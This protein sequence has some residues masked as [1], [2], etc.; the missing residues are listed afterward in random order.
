M[1]VLLGATWLS[2]CADAGQSYAEVPLLVSGS[3]LQQPVLAAGGVSLTVRRAELAFGPL[4]LCAGTQ[5]GDLCETARLEWLDSVRVD[6]MDP[7]PHRAGSLA[8][9]T[10]RVHSWMYDLGISSQLIRKDPFVLNAARELGGASL[11]VEGRANRGGGDV[12]FEVAVVIQQGSEAERG[13]P[14]VRKGTGEVF[15]H[16]VTGREQGLWVQFDAA[17]WL[18]NMDLSAEI[19]ASPCETAGNCSEPLRLEPDGQAYRALHNAAVSGRRPHFSFQP[20]LD[21]ENK[22]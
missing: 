12:P 10:G 20:Q 17:P 11:V 13:V 4:Y 2:A 19:A 21:F 15:N 1:L 16:D 22:R 5:A 7:K 9:T 14:V 8:G 3:D 18:R 6:L